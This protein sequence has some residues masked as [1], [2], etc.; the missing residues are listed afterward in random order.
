MRRV[1][2]YFIFAVIT[3][4][5]VWLGWIFFGKITADE[6]N[7]LDGVP[8]SAAVIIQL[9]NP[10]TTWNHLSHSNLAWESLRI[11]SPF[12]TIDAVARKTDSLMK[13]N[14]S[15]AQL[16]TGSPL[17]ISLHY[18]GPGK[19]GILFTVSGNYD[20]EEILEII[21]GSIS[22]SPVS[23]EFKNDRIYTCRFG[24]NDFFLLVKDG[25]IS[26]ASHAGLSEEAAHHIGE[27]NGFT[28][29]EG[30]ASISAT[31]EPKADAA[32]YIH[33][34]TF[35]SLL[36]SFVAPRYKEMQQQVHPYALF[37]EFDLHIS[38]GS[39]SL[40]GFSNIP[41]SS[42]AFLSLFR[43]H[44]PQ[45]FTAG[46]VMPDNVSGYVWMGFTDGASFFRSLEKYYRSKNRW[47][48][49]NKAILEFDEEHNC[50]LRQSFSEW[51]GNE[52]VLYSVPA[53]GAEDH[54][55]YFLAIRCNDITDP[56]PLLR[57][58][59]ASFS[60]SLLPGSSD[61]SVMQIRGGHIFQLLFGDMFSALHDPYFAKS[62]DYVVFCNS[63]NRLLLSL[64]RLETDH[65]LAKNIAWHNYASVNF[66]GK[67]NIT[68][69]AHVPSFAKELLSMADSSL[70]ESLKSNFEV[71]T[72][73][74]TF[75]WQMVNNKNN[76]F[77]N[78]FSLSYN[79]SGKQNSGA[80]WEIALDTSFNFVP[81][82]TKNHITQTWDVFVQDDNY[83]AYL[84]NNKG[85]LM[86]KK[87][88]E[89][90]IR[91][92]VQQIDYFN[93][94]KQQLLFC[95]A[96]QLHI[97]DLR[98]TYVDGFPVQLL[99]E[100]SLA[101]SVFDY[102]NNGNYRI[103]IPS[104]NTIINLEKNG[105]PVEG[106]SFAGAE[107][108]I[109]Q[110]PK[111]FRSDNKDYIFAC[112]RK[113]N[114]YL[115]DR[116]GNE[117]F[118]VNTVFEKRSAN[119]IFIEPGKNIENTNIVY[120]DSSGMIHKFYFN[121]N[122]DSVNARNVSSSHFF[123]LYDI[124]N[125]REKEIILLDS[126]KVSAHNRKGKLLF[127]TLLPSEVI[128]NVSCATS[129]DGNT[130]FGFYSPPSAQ[131]YVLKGDG[132]LHSQFPLPATTFFRFCDINNDGSLEMAV[133]N[134]SRRLAIYSFK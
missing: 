27:G 34:E 109:S 18:Q 24:Q 55:E 21:S 15:L 101:P 86:W 65:S 97:I 83:T 82:F 74:E 96:S 78:S 114:I 47:E 72:R 20:E 43:E 133:G 108:E 125:D 115:L 75:S 130:F 88:L 69:Y 60:D 54:P 70:A 28:S 50:N 10:L 25:F 31:A 129:A 13:K 73:F 58:L 36:Q 46:K 119:T 71:L 62:G 66:S 100:A 105:K 95:T 112:D 122:A 61:S 80:L 81:V 89:E 104:G 1:L 126:G 8:K 76:L 87:E 123:T 12:N 57:E 98:G 23:R 3:V 85:E 91:G 77:Y 41:D 30:F 110:P 51:M 79:S 68:V 132:T 48:E 90:K 29:L 44:D 56:L 131:C 111:F 63:E 42:Q 128:K 124:N 94:G 19:T 2:N 37:S 99:S 6:K 39:F 116:K 9:N 38:S 35:N 127:S 102:E 134:G 22:G 32:I 4:L 121:G 67:S 93:N 45:E 26:L 84:I 40:N 16:L 33:H 92:D 49:K 103:C 5:V 106:W 117:R 64:A 52:M 118:S 59:A 14:K 113:G 53:G 107:S 120:S 11:I 17:V 7:P